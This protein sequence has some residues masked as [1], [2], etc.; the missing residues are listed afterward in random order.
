MKYSVPSFESVGDL[1]TID[2]ILIS[3]FENMLALPFITEYSSFRGRIYATE[4]TIQIGRFKNHLIIKFGSNS[5]IAKNRQLMHELIF[6]HE[7][8]LNEGNLNANWQNS[9]VLRFV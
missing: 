7:K 8:S 5:S 2:I 3:N 9:S 6:F 4:P 1:S